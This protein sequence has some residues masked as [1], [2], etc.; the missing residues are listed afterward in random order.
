LTTLQLREAARWKQAKIAISRRARKPA[1]PHDLH[2]ILC[3]K[4]RRE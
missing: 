3:F 4:E 1:R 2:R